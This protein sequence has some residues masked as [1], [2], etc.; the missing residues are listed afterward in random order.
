MSIQSLITDEMTSAIAERRPH[1]NDHLIAAYTNG[2]TYVIASTERWND[3]G[4]PRDL[5]AIL[6]GDIGQ[7]QVIRL[8]IAVSDE[9]V[10]AIE[11]IVAGVAR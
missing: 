10:A 8:Y 7:G 4:K 1:H 9:F 5:L 3:S 11:A 2:G 6:P